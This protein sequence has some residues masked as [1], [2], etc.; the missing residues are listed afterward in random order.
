MHYLYQKDE[1]AMPG[2]LQ[3]WKY[4]VLLPPKKCSV[5]YYLPIFF[6]FSLVLFL[7]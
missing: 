1:R 4:N 5:C 3:N 7:T 2:N 6:L